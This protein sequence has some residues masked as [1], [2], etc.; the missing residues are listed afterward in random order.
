LE[1]Y[2]P[3]H[4]QVKAVRSRIALIREF[5]R[6]GVMRGDGDPPAEEAPAKDGPAD[7]LDRGRQALALEL[8]ETEMLRQSL[9]QLL[10]E[11]KTEARNLSNYEVEE[12][13]LRGDITRIQ[14]LHEGT[15][16]RLAEINLVRDAGGFDAR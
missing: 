16:K 8:Q 1:E 9:G 6:T 15:I 7:A 5:V 4:P 13:H 2:G 10:D 14:Q 11:L 3:A 12:D